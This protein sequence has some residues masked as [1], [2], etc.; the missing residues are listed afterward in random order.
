MAGSGMEPWVPVQGVTRRVSLRRCSHG[1]AG[2][3]ARHRPLA[4]RLCPRVTRR[5]PWPLSLPACQSGFRA[6]LV[7]GAGPGPIIRTRSICPLAPDL[8]PWGVGGGGGA[9]GL[10]WERFAFHSGHS[11]GKAAA[12]A[13]CISPHLLSE[14]HTTEFLSNESIIFNETR[15]F[16][17]PNS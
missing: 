1:P 7:V 10:P 12:L 14:Q 4:A 6:E 9:L 15:N 2:N 5:G 13:A 17:H 11:Y 8:T 16:K 3:V